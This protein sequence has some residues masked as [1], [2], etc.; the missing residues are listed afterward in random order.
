MRRTTSGQIVFRI[1]TTDGGGVRFD[2]IDSRGRHLAISKAYASICS[3]ETALSALN[4]M[5]RDQTE[6]DVRYGNGT[7]IV[8]GRS[9]RRTITFEGAMPLADV[10]SLL[11]LTP[12]AK[13]VDHRPLGRRRTDLTGRMCDLDH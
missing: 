2:V 8:R 1:S 9:N 6:V 10:L 13:L 4:S 3:L 11:A 12:T 7:T 5:G